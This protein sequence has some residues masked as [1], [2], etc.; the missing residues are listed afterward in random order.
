MEKLP[1]VAAAVP[2]LETFGLLNIGGHEVHARAGGRASRS[3][4]SAG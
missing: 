2:T 3:T 4:G 1:A